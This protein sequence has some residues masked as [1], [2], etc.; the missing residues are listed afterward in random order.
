MI[1]RLW[2]LVSVLRE[3]DVGIELICTNNPGH[4]CYED[5]YQVAAIP[6][7]DRSWR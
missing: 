4:I 1:R 7:R 2:D 5:R 6:W 3:N